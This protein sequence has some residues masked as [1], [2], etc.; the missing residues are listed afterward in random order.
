MFAL[1]YKCETDA[2]ATALLA[3]AIT[4]A[5]FPTKAAPEEAADDTCVKLQLQIQ[6]ILLQAVR[7]RNNQRKSPILMDDKSKRQSPGQQL[8]A[9]ERRAREA[10]CIPPTSGRQNSI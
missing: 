2:L 1:S 4:L 10:D 7:E 8:D 3:V 5:A 9:V 6:Q